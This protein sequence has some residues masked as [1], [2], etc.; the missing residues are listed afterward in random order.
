MD[1]VNKGLNRNEYLVFALEDA[2][3]IEK[4]L[5]EKNYDLV[6][7]SFYLQHGYS[8]FE[9]L[10]AIKKVRPGLPVTMVIEWDKNFDRS[11]F[12]LADEFIIKSHNTLNEFKQKINKIFH[13]G[14]VPE[15]TLPSFSLHWKNKYGDW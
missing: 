15:K 10:K 4:Q 7:L 8:S 13:H 1:L 14:N 12:K 6:L 9:V 11:L 2:E 3:K 5:E